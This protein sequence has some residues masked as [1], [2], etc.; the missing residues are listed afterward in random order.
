MEMEDQ[1]SVAEGMDCVEWYNACKFVV[2]AML[3]MVPGK[4]SDEI[5]A[6]FADGIICSTILDNNALGFRNSKFFWNSY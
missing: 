2:K 3:E 5:L 1:G 6:V 4:M